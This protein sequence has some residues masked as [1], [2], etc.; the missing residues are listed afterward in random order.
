MIKK[1]NK[2]KMINRT[3]TYLKLIYQMIDL[4]N[5]LLITQALKPIKN[6]L[7]MM[8]QLLHNDFNN[9]IVPLI[10]YITSTKSKIQFYFGVFF[11]PN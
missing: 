5:P 3:L 2:Y 6:K 7:Q 9:L 1:I 10:I 11:A 4:N 8:L